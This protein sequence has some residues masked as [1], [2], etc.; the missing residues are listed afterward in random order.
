VD[1]SLL[2]V[3][4]D[5]TGNY[6]SNWMLRDGAGNLFGLGETGSQPI[7]LNIVVETFVDQKGPSCW[8]C[9]KEQ[10]WSR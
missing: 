8:L 1:L 9:Q 3:T 10:H 4:P 7:A 2:I 5:Q 6:N